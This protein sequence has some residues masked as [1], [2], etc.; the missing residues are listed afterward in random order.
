MCGISG[1]IG[2]SPLTGIEVERVRAV[3]Q[4]LLHRGPDG[5]G[6]FMD[7]DP[8]HVLFAMRR[9]SIIDVEGGAQPLYSEDASVTLVANG[10]IYNFAELRAELISRGYR[11]RTGSDCEV[12]VHLY[13]QYGEAGFAKLRGMFAF[14]LHD[15]RKGC[16]I[17]ARDR[18]GEKPLYLYERGDRLF[19]A[20]EAKAFLRAGVVPFEL[21]PSA[22]FNYLH[23]GFVP[24]TESAIRGVSKLAP[25][26]YLRV[27]LSTNERR[28][29][30]YWDALAASLPSGSHVRAV[31]DELEEICRM[32]VRSDVPI[33]VCLSAGVDSSAVA[34]LAARHSRDNLTA[35]TVGF[36]GSPRQDEREPAQR[37]AQHLGIR[38]I[39]V[40][41]SAEDMAR[42]LPA[43][44][45]ATD[46][47]YN[48]S[49]ASSIY[50]MM[51]RCR[52]EGL[53]VMLSGAGG[54]ELFWGYRWVQRAVEMTERKY[55]RQQGEA[56]ILQYIKPN[57][58]ARSYSQVRSWAREGGGLLSGLDQWFSDRQHGER[59]VFWDIHPQ[60]KSANRQL[61]GLLNPNWLRE[62]SP[63]TPY[64][65]FERDARPER[66]DIEM[67]LAI[68]ETYLCEN[69]LGQTDRLSS[70]HSVEVRNPLVDYRLAE[71]A[72]SVQR[73]SPSHR[74]SPKALLLAA[75][76]D[77]LPEWVKHRPKTGF[78][79]P[80]RAWESET[81]RRHGLLLIDGL[82]VQKGILRREQA[83]EVR[84]RLRAGPLGVHDDLAHALLRLE[85]WTRQMDDLAH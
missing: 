6:Y 62:I 61:A 2:Q 84:A 11:F 75:M 69:G 83:G 13:V 76:D 56:S 67:M 9:L 42:A 43:V 24:G 12:I 14:A 45:G 19:F 57:L 58:P 85:L 20:S 68:Q 46:E 40:V 47:P 41:V 65:T 72:L 63:N 35:V 7:D 36:Q 54:D 80:W 71:L 48:D 70:A 18:M 39:E 27:D 79:N 10:E 37:F 17:L 55:S 78:S 50:A 64:R 33:G 34:T 21:N 51:E 3:N 81:A 59:M 73:A 77:L 1:V 32:I 29:V 4:A 49:A 60:F 23:W 38:H 28:I 15:R 5:H 22:I 52:A 8:P 16:V 66:V 53:K 25:G 82:L 31:R 30:R 74:G 44:C 26:H